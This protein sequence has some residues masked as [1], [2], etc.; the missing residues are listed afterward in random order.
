MSPNAH[1]IASKTG[2]ANATGTANKYI[3]P[4]RRLLPGAPK[5]VPA[6]AVEIVI[7]SGSKEE[8]TLTGS[9]AGVDTDRDL[10]I[11]T[12]TA[13]NLPIAVNADHTVDLHETQPVYILGYPFGIMLALGTGN[14]AITVGTG[15]VSSIRKIGG[16]VVAVQIDGSINPGN[17]GGP[18]VDARGDLIGIAVAKV[19]GTQIGLAIPAHEL[20]EM[21]L[22][23]IASFDWQQQK[24]NSGIATYRVSGKTVDPLGKIRSV[25]VLICRKDDAPGK[26]KVPGDGVW[27]RVSSTMEEFPLTLT[28]NGFS[29]EVRLKIEVPPVV[30]L[31]QPQFVRGDGEAVLLQPS[32]FTAGASKD[33]SA[34]AT[35][36]GRVRLSPNPS[37]PI[38]PGNTPEATGEEPDEMASQ[39]VTCKL[40]ATFDDVCV[41]G[42][43]ASWCSVS[44]RYRSWPFSTSLRRKSLATCLSTASVPSRVGQ[45]RWL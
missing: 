4:K 33:P 19:V 37:R 24:I 8:R 10:A 9:V 11:I 20:T 41:G 12:V 32:E 3:L 1:V 13:P 26:A 31:F 6:K 34:V 38:E 5:F 15:T 17:S 25:S 43:A 44:A 30:Y 45:I 28:H 36:T 16:R 29:G 42:G 21:L 14:P 27:K 7:G 40:P 39:Q 2:I 22:G 23:R 18:I 35:A